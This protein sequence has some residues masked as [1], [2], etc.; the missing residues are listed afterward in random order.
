MG[1]SNSVGIT[2]RRSRPV[3]AG[4]KCS[5]I[6]VTMLDGTSVEIEDLQTDNGTLLELQQA[7]E[8]ALNI[9][10]I[11]LCVGDRVF[12]S[13]ESDKTL[14]ELGI[15]SGVTLLALRKPEKKRAQRRTAARES[16]LRAQYMIIHGIINEHQKRRKTEPTSPLTL[17][18]SRDSRECMEASAFNR[19][20]GETAN[21]PQW[22]VMYG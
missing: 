14:E 19:S 11:M 5:A 16:D 21:Q 15:S 12:D 1:C 7:A 17:E 13:N 4:S 3:E 6:T 20:L 9:A 22:W 10:D 18:G 2:K 8:K